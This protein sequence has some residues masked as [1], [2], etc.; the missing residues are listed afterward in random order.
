MIPHNNYIMGCLLLLLLSA[1]CRKYADNSSMANPAYV[2]VFNDIPDVQTPYNI[3]AVR[4]FFTFLFDPVEDGAGRISKAAVIGDFL[5]T[6]QIYSTS[7]SINQNTSSKAGN[8]PYPKNFDYPGNEH[9]LTAPPLNGFNLSAWAQMPSGKHRIVFMVRPTTDTPFV[10]LPEKAREKNNII[11]DTTIDLQ[12]GEVY[13]LEAVAKDMINNKYGLYF[14]KE[15]F[16]HQQFYSDQLYVNFFNLPATIPP[17]AGE[18]NYLDPYLYYLRDS[19]A[20][21]CTYNFFDYKVAKLQV[22]LEGYNNMYFT[23]LLHKFETSSPYLRLPVL[24]R[25]YFFDP[26]GFLG[27]YLTRFRAQTTLP[28]VV[29]TGKDGSSALSFS[30]YAHPDSINI[31]GAYTFVSNYGNVPL[32]NLYQITNT[33]DSIAIKATVNTIEIVN[34]RAYLMQLQR[35]TVPSNIN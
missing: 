28:Y 32:P 4:P 9:V 16:I 23:T 14:R 26:Q 24:P 34:D 8:A 22:P 20:I 29:F 31:Q 10:R 17:P 15:D 19:I 7:Y 35:L 21:Y 13:T 30:C 5:A 27:N 3:G 33:G 1:G 25:S 11:I 12:Q 2:R 6:R 18:T